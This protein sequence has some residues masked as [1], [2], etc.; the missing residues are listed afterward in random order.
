MV[1]MDTGQAGVFEGGMRANS[2]AVTTAATTI[3]FSLTVLSGCVGLY[4][5]H[6]WSM[7][8]LLI[9]LTDLC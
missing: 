6:N 9:T 4:L 8:Y 5:P 3:F 1:A 7:H 2:A